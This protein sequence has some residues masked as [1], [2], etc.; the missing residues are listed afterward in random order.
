M[1]DKGDKGVKGILSR[2]NSTQEGAE[3]RNMALCGTPSCSI[4]MSY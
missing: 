4:W 1:E 3:K 2:V